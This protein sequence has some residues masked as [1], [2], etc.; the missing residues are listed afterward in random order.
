MKIKFSHKYKKMLDGFERSK[1]LDVIDVNIED[2][3]QHFKEY[4]T[5][6]EGGLYPLPKK[7]PFM[8]LLLLSEKGHLWTTLRRRTPLKREY[9]NSHIGETFDCVII[10]EAE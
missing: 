6:Y 7:G 5:T 8:L 3:S 9:Y 4:D 10:Q 1:L 2:L